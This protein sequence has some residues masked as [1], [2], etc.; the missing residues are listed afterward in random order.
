MRTY[1]FYQIPLEVC[2][3]LNVEIN[4]PKQWKLITS[5]VNF[6]EIEGT[7]N[8]YR[9]PFLLLREKVVSTERVYS[10]K[11]TDSE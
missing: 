7:L 6:H 10:L 1:K 4:C 8:K 3:Y 9:P 11:A 5:A 2:Y